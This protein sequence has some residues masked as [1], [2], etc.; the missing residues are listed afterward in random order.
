MQNSSSEQLKPS[1]TFL[2][3]NCYTTKN[4]LKRDQI[5]E[6]KCKHFV[7]ERIVNGNLSVWSPMKKCKIGTFQNSSYQIEFKDGDKLIKVKE[8]RGLLPRLIIISRSRPELDLQKHIGEFELGLV[9]RSL[10]AAD[11]S[12][13]LATDEYKIRQKLEEIIN[14]EDSGPERENNVSIE[15]E[16]VI[17]KRK[18]LIVDAMALVN[19][20]WIKHSKMLL[21]FQN[22]LMY[23]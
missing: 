2:L 22:L 4:I 3:K 19:C 8:E 6:A 1:S 17:S 18:V 23:F 5:G 10:F 16:I 11:G 21:Y 14:D 12:I 9:P 15:N 7:Q 20:K 13:L